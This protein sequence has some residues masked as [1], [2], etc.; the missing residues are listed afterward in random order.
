MQKEIY[1][2]SAIDILEGLEAVRVRPGMYI[3]STGSQGLHHCIWEIL[4]NC[5]DESIAGYC[6]KIEIIV[7]KDGSVS[8]QDNGR[9]IPIDLHPKAKIP[10]LR[11]IYTIL[12]AGGKFKEG[13]YSFAGGLHGVGASVVNALS[14]YLEVETYH[15]GKIYYDKYEKGKPIIKLDKNGNLK[16]IGK[17]NI[18]SGTKVTFKP[19]PSI[20]E[21]TTFKHQVIYDHLKQTA[22]LNNQVSISYKN[23]IENTNDE[24]HFENGLIDFMK[25]I[26]T[27]ES[28]E[29]ISDIIYFNG[30]F[31][32]MEAEI[33]MQLTDEKSEKI[34]AFVNNITTPDEGTHVSGFRSGLTKCINSY[35]KDFNLKESLNGIDIRN[36]LT[37]IISFKMHDPQFEGQ[38]KGKLGSSI[39]KTAMENIVVNYGTVFFDTHYDILK[40]FID[41][42]IKNMN[43]RKKI[44]KKTTAITKN[45]Y[46]ISNK[47]ADCNS[48]KTEP[49]K[50]EIYIVEGDSAAGTAKDARDRKYHAILALRGKILNI[51]KASLDKV[52]DNKEIQTMIASFTSDQKYGEELD[53]S[54]MRYGKI[55]IMTDADVDGAHITTLLLTFFYRYFKQLIQ[56]GYIY[57]ALTPLYIVDYIEKGMKEK[58]EIFLYNDKELNDFK[59]L[60]HKLVKISRAKGLGELDAEQLET[61]AFNKDTR[62]L[63]NVKIEDAIQANKITSLLMGNVVEG[64]KQLI[65]NESKSYN[66]TT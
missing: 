58:K 21:T 12:H 22:F 23:E 19:D 59:K 1:D 54:K 48:C 52:F 25:D 41:N 27:D 53:L 15:N 29:T 43:E 42:A 14:E 34:F 66:Y 38:T 50:C 32:N 60:G 24:F 51:E 36:G 28:I 39:A 40:A 26:N 9:G 6:T 16:A 17:T 56:E 20:F 13:A 11:V 45:T 49:E 46:E 18:L 64:R 2:G 44:E 4:D 37:A 62:R 55:I 3:G 7:H 33:C 63:V 10:T 31:D 47:L 61:A 5:I 30:K 65:I 57:I 8:I 35:L